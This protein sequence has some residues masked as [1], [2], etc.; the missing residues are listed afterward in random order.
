MIPSPILRRPR[1]PKTTLLSLASELTPLLSSSILFF[2]LVGLLPTSEYGLF[3]TI[4]A[5]AMI[6]TPI[7]RAGAGIVLLR[8]LGAERADESSWNDALNTTIAS[9]MGTVVIWG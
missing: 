3:I 8:D 6:V 9:T 7:A 1:L 4:T 5:S 2:L